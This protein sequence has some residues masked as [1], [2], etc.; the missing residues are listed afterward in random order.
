MFKSNGC[1]QKTSWKWLTLANLP[2]MAIQ[3]CGIMDWYYSDTSLPP[4]D[5]YLWFG[6]VWYSLVWLVSSYIKR[7]QWQ[8]CY[9]RLFYNLQLK[10]VQVQGNSENLSFKSRERIVRNSFKKLTDICECRVALAT[11]KFPWKQ[12]F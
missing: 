11:H 10:K 8:C 7:F 1:L 12:V 9:D 6:M 3:Q 5:T 2:K 4:P